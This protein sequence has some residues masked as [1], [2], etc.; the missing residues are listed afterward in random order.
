MPDTIV[1]AGAH[2]LVRKIDTEKNDLKSDLT[3]KVEYYGNM[4]GGLELFWEVL[5][6]RGSLLRP[7]SMSGMILI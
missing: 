1:N 7:S 5:V 6:I 2:T 3:I 4:T